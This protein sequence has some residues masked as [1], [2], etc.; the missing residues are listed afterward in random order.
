MLP[1]YV[2]VTLVAMV[3][4]WEE[5]AIIF[6]FQWRELDFF[7]RLLI[8]SVSLLF[9]LIFHLV[10]V[11]LTTSFSIFL[12]SSALITQLNFS[13]QLN[14]TPPSGFYFLFLTQL[15]PYSDTPCLLSTARLFWSR[16]FW[17]SVNNCSFSL[18]QNLFIPNYFP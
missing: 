5:V 13:T 8:I 4:F 15:P 17:A 7:R 1:R 11:G 6:L 14:L 12:V 10:I 16:R 9:F 2:V 3:F 18:I